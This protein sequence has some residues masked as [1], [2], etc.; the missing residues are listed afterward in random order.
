MNVRVLD[1]EM[2]KELGYR[3]GGLLIFVVVGFVILGFGCLVFFL[4]LRIFYNKRFFLFLNYVRK[5][6][7][8]VVSYVLIFWYLLFE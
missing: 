3:I 8:L 7:F 4:I 6:R 1:R 5:F 2:L